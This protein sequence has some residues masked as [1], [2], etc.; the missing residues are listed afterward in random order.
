[1]RLC[2]RAGNKTLLSNKIIQFLTALCQLTQVVLYND[3]KKPVLVVV[4]F[5]RLS[6][7]WIKIS[8]AQYLGNGDNYRPDTLVVDSAKAL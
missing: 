3:C 6:P 4:F 1:M 5:S 2:W 8:F 7:D